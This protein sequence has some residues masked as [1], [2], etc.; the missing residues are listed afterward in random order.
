VGKDATLGHLLNIHGEA[1]IYRFFINYLIFSLTNREKGVKL[2]QLFGKFAQ[3]P[4]MVSFFSALDDVKSS[5][6]LFYR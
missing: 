2:R 3:K 5:H 4:P 1:S 6:F